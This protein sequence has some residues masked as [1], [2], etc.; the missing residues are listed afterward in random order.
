MD[1]ILPMLHIAHFRWRPTLLLP[2]VLW[3]LLICVPGVAIS[4][5][6]A[7]P[8]TITLAFSTEAMP[9]YY[10]IGRDRQEI[11]GVWRRMLDTL[12]IEKLGWQ[13]RYLLRPWQRAQN[14]VRLGTAD[15]L[16]TI[17]TEERRQYATP[18]DTAFCCFPLH[19]FTWQGHPQ[20]E[21]MQRVGSVQELA[22]LDLVLVSNIGNGW[23]R[24]NIES[25]GVATTW[26]STDEQ[27]LQFV[28]LKRGDGLIDLPSSMEHLARRLGVE[29]QV[30]DTG[31]SFGQVDVHLMIGKSSP[32]AARVEEIN[33]A[34][35]A[36]FSDGSFAKLSEGS[37]QTILSQDAPRNFCECGQRR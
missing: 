34:M 27:V 9:P 3:L 22:A 29:Q 18:T 15:G 16:I 33:T 30:I 32:F 35:Q 24:D 23:Y 10:T 19:L 4:A 25:N 37:A 11:E 20:M 8:P 5:P 1:H 26:L 21:R 7:A 28:A 14:E 13:V 6:Q 36:L 31:V 2:S 17:A 12:F